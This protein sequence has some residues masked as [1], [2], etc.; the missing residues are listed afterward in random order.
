MGHAE[1]ADVTSGNE[2]TYRGPVRHVYQL[3]GLT[4]L[5]DSEGSE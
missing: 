1:K 5:Q 2:D 4:R 3:P